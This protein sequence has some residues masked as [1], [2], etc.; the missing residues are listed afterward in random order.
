MP[1]AVV[2]R[3]RLIVMSPDIACE[4]AAQKRLV[5]SQLT[6]RIL[7]RSWTPRTW[8]SFGTTVA[9]SIGKLGPCRRTQPASKR[10]PRESAE[11]R[12]GGG[13]EHLDERLSSAA[14]PLDHLKPLWIEDE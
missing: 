2:M 7:N 4:R 9:L 11:P 5:R 6:A 1:S 12:R 14:K 8:L 3:Y 13:A 10:L